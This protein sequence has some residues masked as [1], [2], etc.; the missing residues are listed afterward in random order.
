M[1]AAP[2]THRTLTG[3]IS[4][5]VNRPLP[6]V[7]PQIPLDDQTLSD[8][9]AYFDLCRDSGYNE[10]VIWGFFVDRRWPRT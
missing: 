10:V 9:D 5:F 3:W 1:T 2:F 7:W 8:F 4:E 6:G